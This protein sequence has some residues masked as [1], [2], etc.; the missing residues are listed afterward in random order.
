MPLVLPSESV[1]SHQDTD[2]ESQQLKDNSGVA[3][4]KGKRLE[5][6]ELFDYQSCL[7]M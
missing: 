1:E 2:T 5:R 3:K 6:S 7:C 4:G